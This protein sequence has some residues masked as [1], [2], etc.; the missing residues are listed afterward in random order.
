MSSLM[1]YLACIKSYYY[2]IRIYEY[3]YYFFYEYYKDRYTFF[4]HIGF[5]YIIQKDCEIKFYSIVFLCLVSSINSNSNMYKFFL[6]IVFSCTRFVCFFPKG[7]W[8]I[9]SRTC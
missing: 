3:M 9:L 4:Y 7:K 5:E 8:L 6:V 2:P 1:Q